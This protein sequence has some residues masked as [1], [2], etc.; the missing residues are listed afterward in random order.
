MTI[1]ITIDGEDLTRGIPAETVA[2]LEQWLVSRG[3]AAE[4]A[5]ALARR[6]LIAVIDGA[7][8]VHFER[9]LQRDASSARRGE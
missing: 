1:E 4:E 7:L 6:S 8:R 3:A 2:A 9:A 5:P